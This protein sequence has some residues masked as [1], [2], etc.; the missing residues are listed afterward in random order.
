MLHGHDV[1]LQMMLDNR[2][3]A[4]EYDVLSCGKQQIYTAF[5]PCLSTA[6]YLLT[7]P[8]HQCMSRPRNQGPISAR[9]RFVSTQKLL[10][11]AE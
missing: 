9:V 6:C 1:R 4:A 10:A 5:L 8:A 3:C 11:S 2:T 7:N